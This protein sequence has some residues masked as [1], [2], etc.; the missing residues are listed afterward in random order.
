[1]KSLGTLASTR[2]LG[3]GTSH[4]TALSLADRL[5][6]NVFGQ[7]AEMKAEARRC[8]RDIVN[9]ANAHPDLPTPSVVINALRLAVGN[10]SKRRYSSSRSLAKLRFALAAWY[11]R[12]FG[13]ELDP[14][15]E[16]FDTAGA[17][18]GLGQ[19]AWLLLRAGQTALLPEPA[20]PLHGHCLALSGADVISVPIRPIEDVFSALAT[21]FQAAW[22][23]PS[24][25]LVSF[26]HDP[27]GACVDLDFFEHLVAFARKHDVLI[28]HDFTYG[29]V[30]FDDYRA[31]SILQV[32]GAR[33]V[34]VELV[35]LATS[36][37]MT[38]WHLGLLA[39]NE[40]VIAALTRLRSHLGETA[41]QPLQIAGATALQECD[42]IPAQMAAVYAGRR[43]ALCDGLRSVGWPVAKPRG[44]IF[45]WAPV[46]AR[47]AC[48]GSLEFAKL[49]L[50]EA[51]VAVLPGVGFGASGDGFVR[52]ALGENE[53]RIEQAL[54]GLE[55]VLA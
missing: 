25:I 6:P 4:A 16:I 11:E 52:F 54:C 24:L 46:P 1:M 17:T 53:R 31:P 22:P 27:T 34:A 48:L 21:A 41:F 5:P 20:H 29:Q 51:R 19:L 40:E 23:R 3:G 37:N 47:F 18:E 2:A 39:G 30:V 44:T 43:D 45:V 35:S 38:N 10:S 49:L 14:A 42:E 9:L 55:Q 26:P 13:V 7:L 8:G 36:H 12:G 33:E 28:I 32:P 15:R 50:R